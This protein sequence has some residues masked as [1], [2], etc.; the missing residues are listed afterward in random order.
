MAGLQLSS[1]GHRQRSERGTNFA[2]LIAHIRELAVTLSQCSDVELHSEAA[3]I[4]A[5]FSRTVNQSAP[6]LLVAG[7]AL[8]FEALR[9]AHN[10]ELYDVQ[11]AAV[12]NL[13]QGRIAQ[14]QTG[15]GKTFVAIA[16]ATH[17]ALAGRG[18]HVMTPN[19]YLA[20]RDC[21]KAQ[22]VLKQFCVFR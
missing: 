7:T 19:V 12:L 9:R 21:A 17:L 22:P 2:G 4:R 20:E 8:A 1:V 11:L 13:A 14:M 5:E 18:V 16:T 3:N 6:E 15:E 10:V